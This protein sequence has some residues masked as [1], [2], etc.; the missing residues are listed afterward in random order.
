MTHH[1]QACRPLVLWNR[2]ALCETT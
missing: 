1:L 2:T